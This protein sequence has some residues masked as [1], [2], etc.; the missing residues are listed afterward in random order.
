MNLLFSMAFTRQQIGSKSSSGASS[1]GV[2]NNSSPWGLNAHSS[3]HWFPP[4]CLLR[5]PKIL[6][7]HFRHAL[8]TQSCVKFGMAP[9]VPHIDLSPSGWRLLE[10]TQRRLVLSGTRLPGSSPAFWHVCSTGV[11]FVSE[12]VPQAPIRVSIFCKVS[13]AVDTMCDFGVVLRMPWW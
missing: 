4:R 10:V 5:V 7:T 1:F 12:S 8:Q 13:N 11:F 6:L 9:L 2:N 3:L